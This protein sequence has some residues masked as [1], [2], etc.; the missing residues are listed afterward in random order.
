VC[1]LCRLDCH[2]LVGQLQAVRRGT[3]GWAA[4]RADVVARMAPAFLAD[5]RAAGHVERLIAQ[6]GHWGGT[7]APYVRHLGGV[8]GLGIPLD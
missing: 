7:G 3:P 5:K 4:K 6:V 2:A 8:C 1:Q